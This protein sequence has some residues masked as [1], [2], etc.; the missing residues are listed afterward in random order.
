MVPNKAGSLR[1]RA[2]ATAAG[3]PNRVVECYSKTDGILYA[4]E[5]PIGTVNAAT[6][7]ISISTPTFNVARWKTVKVAQSLWG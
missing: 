6:G 2:F 7:A 5:Q 4:E 1:F 3:E